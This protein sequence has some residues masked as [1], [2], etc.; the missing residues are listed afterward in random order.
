MTNSNDLYNRLNVF[1]LLK[2]YNCF[3]LIVTLG[4]TDSIVKQGKD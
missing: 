3:K 1:E 2:L 4:C